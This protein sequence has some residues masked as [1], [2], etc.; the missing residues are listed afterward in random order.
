[1][2]NREIET[3]VRK[4]QYTDWSEVR[5]Q[6]Q[7]GAGKVWGNVKEGVAEVKEAGEKAKE[8]VLAEVQGRGR[9]G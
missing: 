7:R 8:P 4:V 3:V 9:E 1:M 6:I 5:D 2:W